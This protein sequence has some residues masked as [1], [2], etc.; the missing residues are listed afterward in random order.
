MTSTANV[1]H[2][3][4]SHGGYMPAERERHRAEWT[5]PLVDGLVFRHPQ[6]AKVLV[7][8]TPDNPEASLRTALSHPSTATEIVDVILVFPTKEYEQ[9]RRARIAGGISTPYTVDHLAEEAQHIAQ[10]VGCEF[11]GMVGVDFQAVG[12]VGRTRDLV[13]D[14]VRDHGYTRIYVASPRQTLW[15][16]LLGT[17]DM[18]ASIA[19]VLPAGVAVVPLSLEDDP[20]NS[21]AE[22]PPTSQWSW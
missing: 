13:V 15:E 8:L 16:R 3:I 11:L 17:D 4:K 19:R 1:D 18:A 9:R 21:P 7:V 14:A 2:Y 12:G 20:L 10:R 22:R 6:T 5:L